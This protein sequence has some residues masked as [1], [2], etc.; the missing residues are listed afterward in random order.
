MIRQAEELIIR[1]AKS[2]IDFFNFNPEMKDVVTLQH[3]QL[4]PIEFTDIKSAGFMHKVDIIGCLLSYNE[5]TKIY[6]VWNG[7][8]SANDYWN[9]FSTTLTNPSSQYGKIIAVCVGNGKWVY[10]R[11]TQGTL[12]AADNNWSRTIDIDDEIGYTTHTPMCY[13]QDGFENTKHM[14]NVHKDLIGTVWIKLTRI[15]ENGFLQ[16]SNL[17]GYY[18]IPSVSE[19]FNMYNNIVYHVD[20]YS[21][22]SDDKISSD[23]FN[24]DIGLLNIGNLIFKR[25]L[26]PKG[27]AIVFTSSSEYV[28]SK[29]R[30]L[31][32]NART[33]NLDYV[34]KNAGSYY[35]IAFIKFGKEPISI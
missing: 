34:T 18:Y 20:E 1:T 28:V 29:Q 7:N 9:P 11:H 26:N 19:L 35:C 24:Y 10:T 12:Y 21:V 25:T 33:N 32:Y 14:F 23:F 17:L 5:E 15:I 22:N 3:L 2:I 8:K 4:H 13:C 31:I 16:D 30:N 27:E 6:T